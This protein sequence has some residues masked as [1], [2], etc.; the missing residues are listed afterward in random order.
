MF[1]FIPQL[2]QE[3]LEVYRQVKRLIM[4]VKGQGNLWSPEVVDIAD[5]KAG[6]LLLAL[7]ELQDL[8]SRRFGSTTLPPVSEML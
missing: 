4:E 3:I 2:R 5:L 1:I 6:Q 8:M 7:S